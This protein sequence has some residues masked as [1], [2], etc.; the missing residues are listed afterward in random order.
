MTAKSTLS[1]KNGAVCESLAKTIHLAV[2][3]QIFFVYI[4]SVYRIIICM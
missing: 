4:Y 1:S 3:N 2:L